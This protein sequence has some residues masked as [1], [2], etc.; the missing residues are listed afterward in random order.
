MTYR[1]AYSLKWSPGQDLL[2]IW[3]PCVC[4]SHEIINWSIVT[5]EEYSFANRL[6]RLEF[7]TFSTADRNLILKLIL[8]I[9]Y[10]YWNEYLTHPTERL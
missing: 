2:P 3:A 5:E 1:W 9:I 6:I 4:H 10:Q 8:N 7:K